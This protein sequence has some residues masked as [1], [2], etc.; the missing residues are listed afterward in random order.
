MVREALTYCSR[1]LRYHVVYIGR[2]TG[3]TSIGETLRS[4]GLPNEHPFA[5]EGTHVQVLYAVDDAHDVRALCT[6]DWVYSSLV[7]RSR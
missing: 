5:L 6:R 4:L 2:G 3:T 7:Q 1:K